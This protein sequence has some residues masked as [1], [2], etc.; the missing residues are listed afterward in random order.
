MSNDTSSLLNS[1]KNNPI[2]NS[3]LRTDENEEKSDQPTRTKKDSKLSTATTIQ[4]RFKQDLLMLQ[5]NESTYLSDPS[6][7][8]F[9]EWSE[10][11]DPESFKTTISELLIDDSSMRSLYS[12]LVILTNQYLFLHK[13]F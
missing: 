5:S 2:I 13:E 12:Q 3:L 9:K 8:D 6:H 7:E 1:A 11:F 10:K 4:D